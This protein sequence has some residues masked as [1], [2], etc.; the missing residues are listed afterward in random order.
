[1][2]T[3]GDSTHELTNSNT[4]SVHTTQELDRNDKEIERERA[5]ERERERERERLYMSCEHSLIYSLHTT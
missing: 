2:Y 3:V 1:M 5:H 4:Q